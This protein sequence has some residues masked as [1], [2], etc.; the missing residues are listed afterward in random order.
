MGLN[1]ADE[2]VREN[3]LEY[4]FMPLEEQAAEESAKREEKPS[5][6]ETEDDNPF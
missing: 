3:V 4:K 1:G 5:E 6:E 2:D